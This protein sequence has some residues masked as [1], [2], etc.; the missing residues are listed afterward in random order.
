MVG[1]HPAIKVGGALSKGIFQRRRST[2]S[3]PFAFLGSGFAQNSGKWPLRYPLICQIPEQKEGEPYN[4]SSLPTGVLI[5][6]KKKK[7]DE[8]DEKDI[9]ADRP[10][11]NANQRRK[12]KNVL[13]R[14][15][16]N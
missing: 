3:G 12:V 14:I 11:Y 13:T 5:I 16:G 7:K 10:I 2:G 1:G 15:E 9:N 8:K 6:Q 4:E